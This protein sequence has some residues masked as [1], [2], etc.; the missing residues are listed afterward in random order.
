MRK[1]NLFQLA[2]GGLLA[3]AATLSAGAAHSDAPR[4]VTPNSSGHGFAS[5]YGDIPPDQAEALSTADRIK[6][7]AASGAPT[8]VWEALEHGEKVECLDCI[9]A[10]APLLYDSNAKNREIAAWWLRRRIFG[11]FG[12]GEVYQQ[13]IGVLASDGDP[14]RRAYAAY[15]LGEF[16]AT[17]GIAA[18]AQALAGDTDPGV[19]AAAASALGRLNDDGGGALGA[20]LGD[21]DASVKIAALRAAAR[22]NAFSGLSSVAGLTLDADVSVRRSAVQVLDGLRA[23]DTVMVVLAVAQ[24][25]SDAGV[26]AAACHA[27]GTFGDAT[28]LV[29]LQGIATSDPDTFVR[30]Q[31]QIA[32]RRL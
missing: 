6:S 11:V 10:V 30:D 26:R 12:Q 14:T 16:F 22:I 2:V 32:L 17:P 25:D 19:R 5:V 9:G 20:A 23:T 28:T 29:A 15:A 8:L 7:A 1:S 21:S 13:T 3:A 4:Q 27:L 18:C 31:A 24:K